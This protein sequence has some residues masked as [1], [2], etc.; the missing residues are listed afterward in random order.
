MKTVVHPPYRSRNGQQGFR[1]RIALAVPSIN[2][3]VLEAGTGVPS[4]GCPGRGKNKALF[5]DRDGVINIEGCYVHSR[6]DFCFLDGIFELCMEVQNL[7]YLLVV[8][9][10]QSGIARAYYAESDFLELTEWMIHEFARRGIQIARVYYCPFHPVM[11][12]GRYKFDSPDR[13]PK[14]GM[15]QRAQRELDLNMESS[16]LIG[17][18]LCDMDA[19]EAAGV[20][21]KILLRSI[22]TESVI[23]KD[24]YYFSGS[25][26]E[27]RR[28]FFSACVKEPK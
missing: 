25:L 16:V 10:N 7:G 1:N 26:D 24:R 9:T 18:K 15:L 23:Q 8:V 27:I 20:G 19:A 21:T 22:A 14:P 3:H 4:L 12:V 13:K 11:G 17:D 2:P 28:Q 6:E 5:L